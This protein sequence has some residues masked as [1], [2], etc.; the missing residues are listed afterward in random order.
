MRRITFISGLFDNIR[1]GVF[2]P[3]SGIEKEIET[4]LKFNPHYRELLT[5]Y[6][7]SEDNAAI[8][9]ANNLS[10]HKIITDAPD[11]IIR[12]SRYKMKQWMMYQ[13]VKEF[14]DVVWI[15]W[16]TYNKRLV[17]HRFV[18]YC[19]A[20][21]TPKFTFIKGGYWAVVNC[22]VYYANRSHLQLFEKSF[23]SKVSEP[24]DEL[25]W[26]SVLP[27]D[28][29]GRKEYWFGDMVVNI[30]D[31]IDFKD[32]TDNTYFLHLKDFGLL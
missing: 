7:D 9:Q 30:W 17:D 19:L 23:S 5:C 13:A 1:D 11:S 12:D 16:D 32:V 28:I 3:K 26:A 4:T 24:N 18:D 25:M 6:A 10:V 31:R 2:S 22:A 29:V 21:N 27:K 20:T 14:G 8:M 15:D